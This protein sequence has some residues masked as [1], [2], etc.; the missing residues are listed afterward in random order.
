[1]VWTFTLK[2]NVQSMRKIAQIFV[3]FSESPNFKKEQK[4]L[5]INSFVNYIRNKVVLYDRSQ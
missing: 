1:M 3:C 4:N 5:D 2:V